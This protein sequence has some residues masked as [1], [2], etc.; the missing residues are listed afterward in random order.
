MG[1]LKFMLPAISRNELSVAIKSIETLLNQQD[2][3]DIIE[4]IRKY[5]KNKTKNVYSAC[6][7]KS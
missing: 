7:I 1:E 5:K 6:S 2:G 4:L 3:E